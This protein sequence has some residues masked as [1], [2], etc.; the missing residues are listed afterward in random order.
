MAVS[1]QARIVFPV[2]RPPIEHG[3]VTIDG[4][5]IVAVG[6]EA[7]A[8]EVIDLDAVALLPGLVNAH[9]H[10]EFSHL[11]RPLGAPG[12]PLADWIRLVIAERGQSDD[13]RDKAIAAGLRESIRYGVTTIGEILAGNA[14]PA[15]GEADVT[16]FLEVIGFSRARA[17]SALAAAIERIDEFKRT[18]NRM[19]LGV[20]P[21]APYTV[22]PE[23]LKQLVGLACERGFPIAMHLAESADELELLESGIGR[24]QELLDERS[25]WDDGAIPSGSRPLDYLRLLA[26]SPRTLVIHGNFLDEEERAWLAA[27][28]ERMSLIYCPR[29]HSY[30]FHPPLPLSQLLAIGVRVALGTDSRASTPDL[31]LLAEM[32]HVARLHPQ[33]DPHD[34]LRMGTLNGALALGREHEVGRIAPGTLANLVAIPLPE[35]AGAGAS[36]LLAALFAD[37]AAPRAVWLRGKKMQS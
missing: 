27:N 23:L 32:R 24:F 30:F 21:H 31:D 34:I 22:S 15:Y 20:S 13:S 29:T 6:A 37:D 12:M 35:D 36:D 28:S 3:F 33:L 4:E 11:S 17:H 14:S 1:L 19:R 16:A 18:V 25:M 5:R 8:D 9:T 10:L 26:E 2:D 7:A